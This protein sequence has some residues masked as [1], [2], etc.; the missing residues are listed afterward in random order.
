MNLSSPVPAV[1][2]AVVMIFCTALNTWNVTRSFGYA[3]LVFTFMVFTFM[4]FI[5]CLV[6]ANMID[7]R[8]K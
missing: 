7:R 2:C 3:S 6:I 8:M 1:I 5:F 4:A